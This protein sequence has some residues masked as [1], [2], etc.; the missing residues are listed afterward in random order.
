MESPPTPDPA[1][2]RTSPSGATPL[3]ERL[4]RQLTDAL[5]A[6][7]PWFPRD[8]GNRSVLVGFSGGV[9]STALLH[10]LAASRPGRGPRLVAA[11]L[12]H[13]LRPDS[14]KQAAFARTV[15]GSLG[16]EC[17]GARR[18]VG[19]RARREGRSLEEAARLER[20]DFFAEVAGGRKAAA[21]LL[22]HTLTDQAETVLLR[23]TR[24]AG[25]LGLGAMAPVRQD[26]RGIVIVRPLLTVSR[27]EIAELVAEEGWP[28]YPDPTNTREEFV[29]N[30]VRRR[31]LPVLRTSINPQTEAALG[32]TASLLRDDEEWLREITSRHFAE[33]AEVVGRGTA[34]EVRFPVAALVAAHPALGRR[35]VREGLRRARGHLRRIGLVHVEAVLRLARVGRRG[36][37]VDLPGAVTQLDGPVLRILP[38]GTDPIPETASSDPDD[39]ADVEA[40]PD[41]E[42]GAPRNPST[43]RNL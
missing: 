40:A 13:A 21:V 39:L 16:I 26:P 41:G 5:E 17:V 19:A 24:G 8:A 43:D 25:G 20:L 35:L 14:D 12:D 30:R 37:S 28:C 34:T 27:G 10:L 22:G 38:S 23:L 36:S 31:V 42:P 32:R 29:R 33:I 9:D 1:G 6:A 4:R 3:R 11:H 15:A 7:L 18:D 2:V